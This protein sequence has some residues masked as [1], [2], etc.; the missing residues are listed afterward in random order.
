MN[1]HDPMLDEP[2]IEWDVPLVV[3]LAA[4]ILCGALMLIGA[5]TVC[6]WV[7]AWLAG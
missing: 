3:V 2:N 4:V 6:G 5:G 7:L 1:D